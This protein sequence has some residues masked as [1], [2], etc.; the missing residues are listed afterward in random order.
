MQKQ[1]NYKIIVENTRNDKIQQADLLLD[2]VMGVKREQRE[3][4]LG[5]GFHPGSFRIGIAGPPGAGKSTFINRFGTLLAQKDH[6]VAVIA[7]DPSSTKSKGSILG[8]K[9]RMKELLQQPNVYVR[10]AA[11]GGTLGG[12]AE[13]T[14]DMVHLVEAAGY[15]IV[16]VETVGLGQLE[17]MVDDMVDMFMLLMPPLMGDELQGVKKGV[18]EHADIIVISKA[19]GPLLRYIYIYIMFLFFI[20]FFIY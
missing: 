8:D 17:V 19:D 6:K 9:T 7:I 3:K 14:V 12:V 11:S 20:F 2:Y 5:P 4:E 10:A 1:N 16:I 13:N 15:D 18:M